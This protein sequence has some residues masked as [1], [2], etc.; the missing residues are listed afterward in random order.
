MY[1]TICEG[2]D[3]GWKYNAMMR[4]L[5]SE[6]GNVGVRKLLIEM[7]AEARVE[8]MEKLIEGKIQT[9]EI[10]RAGAAAEVNHILTSTAQRRTRRAVDQDHVDSSTVEHRLPVNAS[11]EIVIDP[12]QRTLDEW[13][14]LG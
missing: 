10:A 12:M 4:D 11:E 1:A 6:P 3:R 14:Q 9:E 5:L 7:R 2:L 8:I 13:T